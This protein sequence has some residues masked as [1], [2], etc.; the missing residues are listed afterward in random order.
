LK[1]AGVQDAGGG[2]VQPSLE[3]TNEALA[4]VNFPDNFRVFEGNPSRGYPIV[5]LTW[6]MVYK[7]YP[8]AAQAE[9]VKKWLRWVLTDGQKLNAGKDFAQ[10]EQSVRDRALQQV[11][12]IK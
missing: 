7:T 3:N 4:S 10:I 6:M 9:A 12:S 11:E 5:G 2:F 1:I 8:D